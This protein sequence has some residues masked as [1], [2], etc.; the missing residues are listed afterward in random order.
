VTHDPVKSSSAHLSRRKN[1][2][3]QRDS[4]QNRLGDVLGGAA[5]ADCGPV[6]YSEEA[7]FPV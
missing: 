6:S 4:V 1:V 7:A 2:V 5:A 3:R